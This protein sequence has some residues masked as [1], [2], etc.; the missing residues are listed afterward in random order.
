MNTEQLIHLFLAIYFGVFVIAKIFQ[1][2]KQKSISSS[3]FEWTTF[4]VSIL[5]L[6][7]RFIIK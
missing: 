5:D 1:Y 7:T 2:A 4:G 6:V 3:I